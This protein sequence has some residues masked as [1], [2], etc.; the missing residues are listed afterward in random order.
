[1]DLQAGT[2]HYKMTIEA[3]GQTM[4]MRISTAIADG[5]ASWTA[6]NVIETPQ[7]NVTDKASVEKTTLLLQKRNVEQ[8]PITIDVSFEGNK[9]SGKMSMNGQDKPISVDLG[10]PVFADAAGADQEIA[11]LP[12]A[13]GYTT[14]YRN[15]DFQSQKVRL[16]QLTVGGVEKVTVPAGT[17]D[18]YKVDVTSADGGSDT[19]TLWVAKDSHKVVKVTAVVASMGGAKLTE[20]LTD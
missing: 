10:G 9:A 11:C 2:Y 1:M 19:K 14:T 7:G 5:G 13:E 18:A 4:N 3:G 15:F 8:G 20:E 6:T 12:L 16:L 17:F